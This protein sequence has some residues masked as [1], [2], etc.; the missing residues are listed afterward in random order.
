MHIHMSSQLDSEPE[1]VYIRSFVR[2][3]FKWAL[4]TYMFYCIESIDPSVRR[5]RTF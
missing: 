2:F 4:K 1:H 3:S 5:L